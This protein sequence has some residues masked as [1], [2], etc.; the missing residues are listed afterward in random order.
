MTLGRKYELLDFCRCQYILV[1]EISDKYSKVISNCDQNNTNENNQSVGGT[2]R[3]TF[4]P[5]LSTSYA[6]IVNGNTS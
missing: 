3:V 4:S 5:T 6:E 2:N 1:V